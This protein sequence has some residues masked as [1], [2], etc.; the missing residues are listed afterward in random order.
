MKKKVAVKKQTPAQA[1]SGEIQLVEY[2]ENQEGS[3]FRDAILIVAAFFLFSWFT[4]CSIEHYKADR[5]DSWDMADRYYA[6][7]NQCLQAVDFIGKQ[8]HKTWSEDQWI[9][10]HSGAYNP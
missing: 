5:E 10:E 9:Y 6:Q 3:P 1:L 8:R 2:K 7:L 4:G